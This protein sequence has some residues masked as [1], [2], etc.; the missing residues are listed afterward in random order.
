MF[1]KKNTMGQKI[2]VIE[3]SHEIWFEVTK[4]FEVELENGTRILY[5]VTE[6]NKYGEE[7]YLVKPKGA[8]DYVNHWGYP[9]EGED[10]EEIKEIAEKLLSAYY[11]GALDYEGEEIDLEE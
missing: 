3:P 11:D 6:N 7:D 5:R 4:Q 10:S 2:K 1:N 9:Y 8:D